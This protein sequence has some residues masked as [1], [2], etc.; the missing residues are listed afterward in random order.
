VSVGSTTVPPTV[1]EEA[2][3][4][5]LHPQTLGKPRPSVVILLATNC[6]TKVVVPLMKD[7][8]AT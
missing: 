7:V 8:L 4:H 2:H 3:H 5:R 6:S 1:G